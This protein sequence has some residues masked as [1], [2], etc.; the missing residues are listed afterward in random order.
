MDIRQGA[1]TVI[2]TLRKKTG[3]KIEPVFFSHS[4][5]LLFSPSLRSFATLC[6]KTFLYIRDSMA[7]CHCGNNNPDDTLRQDRTKLPW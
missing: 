2:D 4:P 7:S 5:Y 6:L 1:E 3:S